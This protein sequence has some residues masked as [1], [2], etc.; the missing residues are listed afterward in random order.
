MKATLKE[1][2]RYKASKLYILDPMAQRLPRSY[3]GPVIWQ[4]LCAR[5]VGTASH[6]RYERYKSSRTMADAYTAG[7]WYT[8][9]FH[10]VRH[11][12]VRADGCF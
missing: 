10:D 3:K 6:A 2:I 7:M 12:F 1:R 4:Q 5:R 8:D 11:G 9:R